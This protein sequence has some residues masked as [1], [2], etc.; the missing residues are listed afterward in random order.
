MY[1]SLHGRASGVCMRASVC[2]RADTH[3]H[4]PTHTHTQGLHLY[5]PER[6]RAGGGGAV[7][8]LQSDDGLVE[9]RHSPT[10]SILSCVKAGGHW[11]CEY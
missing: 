4:P 1:I 3:T 11:L 10:V 2:A 7:V 9:R 8:W 5:S 6:E